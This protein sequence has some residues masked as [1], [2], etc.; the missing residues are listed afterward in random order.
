[1]VGR[2]FVFLW[3]F[4]LSEIALVSALPNVGKA[5]AFL[6]G[7]DQTNRLSCQPVRCSPSLSHGH[8]PVPVPLSSFI[9]GEC[10]YGGRRI[11]FFVSNA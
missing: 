5:P 6:S 7:F 1:M 10:F 4:S 9:N 11:R 8:V 3:A 2:S